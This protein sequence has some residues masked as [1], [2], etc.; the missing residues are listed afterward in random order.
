M[1]AAG[2]DAFSPVLFE[3]FRSFDDGAGGID[4]VVDK[5]D[6]FALHIAD[7]IHHFRFVGLF[8]T[9]VDDRHLHTQTAGEVASSGDTAD[10]GAGHHQIGDIFAFDMFDEQ[11][12]AVEVV[13]GNVE[14][15]L[16]LTGVQIHRHDSIDS[17]RLDQ[18]GDQ[19]RRDRHTGGRFAI[20]AGVTEIGHDRRDRFGRT[21]AQRVG[22][23]QEFHQIVVGRCPGG[24]DDK[25]IPSPHAL[26]DL[27]SDLSVTEAANVGTAK[28]HI[29][30]TADLFREVLAGGS[31]KEFVSTHS[32]D[33]TSIK[34]GQ[35]YP[36]PSEKISN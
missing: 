15:T 24:L 36:N 25:D 23:D 34:I 32:F 20:L 2:N 11:N 28:G 31:C 12:R 33:L 27:T 30:Q 18:V 7:D 26:T 1:G 6:V 35:L 22:H 19:L 9:L 14:K 3:G 10:V 5:D 29:E 13:D 21:A 8:A 17:R 16:D 4:H